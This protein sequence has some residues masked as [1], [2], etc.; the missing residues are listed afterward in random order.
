MVSSFFLK[1]G[2]NILENNGD[3]DSGLEDDDGDDNLDQEMDNEGGSGD[4]D[5]DDD[6]LGGND[7]DSEEAE[8]KQDPFFIFQ[9]LHRTIS[10]QQVDQA[11]KKRELTSRELEME[12]KKQEFEKYKKKHQRDIKKIG[13]KKFRGKI[14]EDE[15]EAIK[16]TNREAVL[17]KK[18]DKK[19]G[20]LSKLYKNQ[21]KEREDDA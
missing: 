13:K 17:G 2:L 21:K 7:N 15:G 18:E 5:G 20:L 9:F 1:L 4:E 11:P 14:I 3:N 8:S 16:V 6:G 12:R 19:G 10:N